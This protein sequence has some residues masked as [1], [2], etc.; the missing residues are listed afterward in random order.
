MRDQHPSSPPDVLYGAWLH[1]PSIPAV[2]ALA[3]AGFDYL[4]ADLQHGTAAEHDLPA[5]SA[6][7]RAAGSRLLARA[8][9]PHAAD[10]GRA[11]DL[12]ASGVIVPSLHS[13]EEA[14]AAA[15]ACR[16]PPAGNRSLGRVAGSDHPEDRCILMIETAG[17]LAAVADIVAEIRPD[18]I[19]V[20]PADLSASLGCT[21]SLDDRDFSEAISTVLT[22]CAPHGVPVGVHATDVDTALRFRELG[23]TLVTCFSDM[24][25]LESAAG[26]AIG[27]LK[28]TDR[29]SP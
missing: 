7:A 22:A 27:R 21:N 15:A 23:C 29:R 10:L 20:G 28:A 11:L 2:T 17:A 5:L 9:S 14:R 18:G 4:V 13:L 25:S 16:Y 12:G 8:R 26:A 19:Y 6:A 1:T 24:P 3:H